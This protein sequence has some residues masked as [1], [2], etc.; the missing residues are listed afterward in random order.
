MK[1]GYLK[2]SYAVALSFD[3]A[4]SQAVIH[5]LQ[6]SY[7]KIQPFLGTFQGPPTRNITWAQ[8]LF[9]LPLPPFFLF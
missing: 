9:S 5:P 4:I 1:L 7:K 6:G 3:T 8:P 2:D